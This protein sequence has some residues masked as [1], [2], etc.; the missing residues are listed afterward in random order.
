MNI[1][2]EIE[3]LMKQPLLEGGDEELDLLKGILRLMAS[4]G[5][6]DYENIL[7][8]MTIAY[9]AGLIEGKRRERT[10]K[11]KAQQEISE[12]FTNNIIEIVS[13]VR[14]LDKE[15]LE[16]WEPDFVNSPKVVGLIERLI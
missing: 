2:K 3:I 12:E 15:E 16:E 6:N 13:K 7:V 4:K 10:K 8:I 11:K 9:S 1:Q 5:F 14:E